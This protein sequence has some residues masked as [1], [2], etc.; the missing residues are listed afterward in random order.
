MSGWRDRVDF[1]SDVTGLVERVPKSGVWWIR[2]TDHIGKRHLEKAGRRGD[3]IDPLAKRKHEKLLRKKLPEKLRGKI[4][5]FG[6][7]IKD[8]LAH[9]KEQNSGRSTDELN[10]KLKIIARESKNVRPRGLK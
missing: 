9:S 5:T 4:L 1:M 8:A 6:D 7:L 2:W 3:A 10:L